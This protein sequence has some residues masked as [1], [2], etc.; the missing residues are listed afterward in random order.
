MSAMAET[1]RRSRGGW[2]MGWLAVAGVIALCASAGGQVAGAAEPEK[3]TKVSAEEMKDLLTVKKRIVQSIFAERETPAYIKQAKKWTRSQQPDGSWKDIDYVRL[4][5]YAWNAWYHVRRVRHLAIAYRTKGD[6][7]FDSPKVRQQIRKGIDFWLAGDFTHP[8]WWWNSIG[9]PRKLGDVCI[10]MDGELTDEQM[11]ACC[12]ILGRGYQKGKWKYHGDATGQNLVWMTGVH[13]ARG[14]LVRSPAEVGKALNR[15]AKE[16]FISDW[17]GI[18]SDMSFWQHGSLLYSGGYGRGFSADCARFAWYAHG[19]RWEFPAAKTKLLTG[20]ILDGQQW[21]IRGSHFDYG[22]LGREITR[23]GINAKPIT[24]AC[25]YMIR[26]KS[27]RAAEFKAF[28]DRLAGD[29]APGAGA[30]SGNRS[31]WR[32]AFMTHRREGYLTS[33]RMLRKKLRN[34][35]KAHNKEGLRSH[36]LSSGVTYIFRRGDEYVDIFPVWDW[37]RV[38]GIT[39][40]RSQRALDPK[41]VHRTGI[42]SFAGG[43]SDGTYGAAAMDFAS[44]W[45]G[46]GFAKEQLLARKAWFYFDDE[47]VCLGAGVTCKSDDPVITSLNQCHLRGPVTVSGRA[48]VKTLTKG[49]HDFVDP[50]WVHHDGVGYLFPVSAK[51][52]VAN[53]AQTGSWKHISGG[54]SGKKVSLPVFSAWIE[55]GRAPKGARYAYVVAPDIAAADMAA[56]AK[57]LP[58]EIVSNT[59]SVQA[60]RHTKLGILQVAMYQAGKCRTPEGK[61]EITADGSCLL[62]V[63]DTIPGFQIAAACPDRT[64]PL[65]VTINRWLKGAGVTYSAKTGLSTVTF[66]MP[67]KL[68]KGKSVVRKFQ[69][70]IR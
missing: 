65:V 12:K 10:L 33:A 27:P 54:K 7:L 17:E 61:F 25:D 69:V 3:E 53:E 31:F 11:A 52:H 30:P 35:D 37:R 51:V 9:L 36:H 64:G 42:R 50:S 60:V 4:G 5:S 21:M 58:I 16:I 23:E 55:H 48:G 40:E 32:S 44:L 45:R 34:T 26:L 59:K 2:R 6:P 8:N 67:A 49:R 38:P 28:R 68:L 62:M 20:Y 15:M 43:I 46:E 22:T 56:Y 18:Q 63:T 70:F 19:T 66:D 57:N 39:A 41:H 24:Q 13:V 29:A 47:F 1:T 14:C